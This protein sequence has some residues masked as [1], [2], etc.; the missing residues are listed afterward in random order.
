ML[1]LVEDLPGTQALVFSGN[2]PGQVRQALLGAVPGTLIVQ[3]L[4]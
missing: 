3:G 1:T 4:S 2:Q